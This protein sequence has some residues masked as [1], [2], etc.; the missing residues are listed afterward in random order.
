MHF[1]HSH[2]GFGRYLEGCAILSRFG[3]TR[4]EAA[5]VSSSGDLKDIHARKVVM[6]TV[7]V[8]YCGP[9]D[10]YSAHLSWWSE[11]FRGQWERLRRW[12][13]EIRRPGSAGT[14]LC[15]DFN[16]PPGSEG[17][18]LATG[19]GYADQFSRAG[20]RSSRNGAPVGEAGELRP[21]EHRLD[22]L[23]LDGGAAIQA[24][25]AR[26]LFTEADYGRVSDH[27]GYLVEFEPR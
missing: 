16:V 17:Y 5:Y 3:F 15:G 1:D 24:V 18:A 8:P 20:G 9:V 6:G 4:R 7:D 12:S 19:G 27:A 13:E 14:L 21:A 11:G 23:L 22:Y 10:V 2:I 25:A 26:E